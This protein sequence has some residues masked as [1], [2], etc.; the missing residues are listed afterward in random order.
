MDAQIAFDL[1]LEPAVPEQEKI[2]LQERIA[3]PIRDYSLPAER[4]L[5]LRLAAPA[6]GPAAPLFVP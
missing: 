1:T 4:V 6:A 3:E 5:Q 2:F